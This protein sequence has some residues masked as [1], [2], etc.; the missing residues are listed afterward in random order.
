MSRTVEHIVACHK[1]ASALRRAG[2]PIWSH[3]INLHAI[4]ASAKGQQT[5]E[6]VA[7]VGK[8][9]AA[10]IRRLPSKYFDH[11]D[12]ACNFDFL[13]AVEELELMTAESLIRDCMD[14]SDEPADI[15]DGWLDEIYHWCDRN[16]VWTRG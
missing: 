5:A 3:T 10:E 6:Q 13:N 16:R 1:H 14:S 15:L 11:A 7:A 4:L 2:K 12:G 9:L 8:L